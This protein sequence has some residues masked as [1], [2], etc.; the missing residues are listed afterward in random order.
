VTHIKTEDFTMSRSRTNLTFQPQLERLEARDLP[1]TSSL[2]SLAA[3]SPSLMSSSLPSGQISPPTLYGIA[4]AALAVSPIN[5]AKSIPGLVS[6]LQTDQQNLTAD[7][8]SNAS[9][10]TIASAYS[11]A[12]N[13][14]G[15]IKSANSHLTNTAKTD[16]E[17]IALFLFS[18]VLNSTDELLAV[19]TLFEIESQ[20]K[21]A[22]SSVD[23]ANSIA[24][25]PEPDGFP[26][27]A[28]NS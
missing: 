5:T 17:V 15:Q 24:N 8:N 9:T 21:M 28:A 11:G 7:I 25:T 1:S 18:G 6:Q 10:A 2:G 22:T 3:L 26:T 19:G 16:T 27:I 12:S 13:V 20:V 14:Y 23:M 4:I